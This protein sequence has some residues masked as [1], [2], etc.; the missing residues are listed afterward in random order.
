MTTIKTLKSLI[1]VLFL[2]LVGLSKANAQRYHFYNDIITDTSISYADRIGFLDSIFASDTAYLSD[3]TA[4]LKYYTRWKNEVEPSLDSNGNLNMFMSVLQSTFNVVNPPPSVPFVPAP[5]SGSIALSPTQ[6]YANW[7]SIGPEQLIKNRT[8]SDPDQF[9]EQALGKMDL[10]WPC[11]ANTI[12]AGSDKGGLFKTTD[13]GATWNALPITLDDGN[14]GSVFPPVIGI[15]A[16]LVE[17][18]DPNNVYVSTANGWDQGLGTFRSEDGGLTWTLQ[19]LITPD[20]DGANDIFRK[21]VMD[22]NDPDHIYAISANKLFE[23]TTGGGVLN[24][25]LPSDWVEINTGTTLVNADLKDLEIDKDNPDVVYVSGRS[26]WR[27][28]VPTIGSIVDYKSKMPT[29]SG[30]D[31]GNLFERPTFWSRKTT[32]GSTACITAGSKDIGERWDGDI[33]IVDDPNDASYDNKWYRKCNGTTAQVGIVL[34][35]NQTSILHRT[36]YGKPEFGNGKGL[37]NKLIKDVK[38]QLRLTY[39][40]LPPNTSLKIELSS[41]TS[42]ATMTLYD[43]ELPGTY[44][45]GASNWVLYNSNQTRVLADDFDTY[46]IT[47]SATDDFNESDVLT[48]GFPLTRVN[49]L[50]DLSSIPF[51]ACKIELDEDNYLFAWAAVSNPSYSFILRSDDDLSHNSFTIL[52]GDDE[53]YEAGLIDAFAITNDPNGGDVIELFTGSLGMLK[54]RFDLNHLD[55]PSKTYTNPYVAGS[56]AHEDYRD[57]HLLTNT[58]DLYVAHDGGLMK[59]DAA[60]TLTGGSFSQYSSIVGKGLTIG[61]FW[62]IDM[63]RKGSRSL[64]GGG[65]MHQGFYFKDDTDY[66]WRITSG[67]DGGDL[68]IHKDWDGNNNT[69]ILV[70]EFSGGNATGDIKRLYYDGYSSNNTM[71]LEQAAAGIP[72]TYHVIEQAGDGTYYVAFGNT[73]YRWDG[74]SQQYVTEKVFVNTSN[75]RDKMIIYS[76]AIAP[77]DPDVIYVGIAKTMAK[78]GPIEPRFWRGIR[79]S[80]GVVDWNSLDHRFFKDPIKNQS[81]GDIAVSYSDPAKVWVSF[82]GF[83]SDNRRVYYSSNA[84]DPVAS[85]SFDSIQASS[86]LNSFPAGKL[87]TVP[88]YD[89]EIYVGT[90]YGLYRGEEVSSGTWSWERYS[91]CVPSVDWALGGPHHNLPLGRVVDIKIDA[92]DNK[93]LA[94]VYGRGIW[95]AGL[96]CRDVLGPSQT[97]STNTTWSNKSEFVDHNIH[98]ASLATLTLNDCDLSFAPDAKIV[99][100]VGGKLIVNNSTLSNSCSK[101]WDGIWVYGNGYTSG[102]ANPQKD[103]GEVEINNSLI[104]N[105]EYGVRVGTGQSNSGGILRVED[106][107]FRNCFVGISYYQ[108]AYQQQNIQ[109]HIKRTKFYCDGPIPGHGGK[110]VHA[111]IGLY[112]IRGLSI[113]GCSFYNYMRQEDIS[114]GNKGIGIDV[115]DGSFELKQESD[116]VACMGMGSRNHFEGLRYGVKMGGNGVQTSYITKIM[117]SDFK[118]NLTGIY[119]LNQY[120]P[121]M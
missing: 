77:S 35:K 32:G 40:D 92:N 26:I 31:F 51:A 46:T 20:E 36:T 112:A 70:H 47:A 30:D 91:K 42:P 118:N 18:S 37:I 24:P 96:P 76:V 111:H 21:M 65:I 113:E 86:D 10:V 17:D 103:G 27:I 55:D 102:Q 120:K 34:K 72:H 41:S 119:L 69:E 54:H 117:E 84:T 67:P 53:T 95:E 44:S 100:E 9:T 74:S 68:E 22:P 23:T 50:K 81:V 97:I 94:S 107:E 71:D 11:D 104:E 93:I 89:D 8:A 116:P 88:F 83:H 110:G 80:G 73:L 59:I 121:L 62:S 85:V 6:E 39:I 58:T 38:L 106:S 3:S 61:H 79:Q 13:G 63:E 82:L 52:S 48:L 12:Y 114:D 33:S 15:R 108:Y 75:S 101:E 66:D 45:L 28:H 1:L 99:V 109:G 90:D 19:Y 56:L 49:A 87:A 98:V 64:M 60:E 16:L 25:G 2:G 57:F 7:K 29:Y 4:R 5:G 78:S 105:G 14:G 43:S 115:W